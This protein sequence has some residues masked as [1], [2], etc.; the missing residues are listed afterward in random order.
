MKF[1]KLTLYSLYMF[2]VYT[3]QEMD[4]DIHQTRTVSNILVSAEIVML[5]FAL[6][7]MS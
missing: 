2:V 4:V 5:T 3:D 7:L 6:L 1:S